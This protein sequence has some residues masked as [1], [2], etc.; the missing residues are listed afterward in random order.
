[1]VNEGILEKSFRLGFWVS[2]WS[3]IFFYKWENWK[4]FWGF[5]RLNWKWMW[6]SQQVNCFV[7]TWSK[8]KIDHII[9]NSWNRNTITISTTTT[10]NLYHGI[11]SFVLLYLSFKNHHCCRSL[12]F[13]NDSE[14]FLLS[15]KRHIVCQCISLPGCNILR[16]CFRDCR[17]LSAARACPRGL[18]CGGN[19]VDRSIHFPEG[20]RPH[21]CKMPLAGSDP[22][23]K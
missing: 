11:Y 10:Q 2:N 21:A 7:T 1:M 8:Q 19:C 16:V 17:C 3:W 14:S 13:C 22:G 5:S 6:R 9:I 4:L 15:T 12:N 18:G 23:A 20:P